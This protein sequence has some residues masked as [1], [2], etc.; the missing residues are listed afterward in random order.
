M[1]INIDEIIAQVLGDTNHNEPSA[2]QLRALLEGDQNG[3][4]HFVNLLAFKDKARYPAEHEMSSKKLSG[5]EAYDKYGAVAFE[6]ITKRGGRMMALANVEKQLVG[7]DK[8]WDRIAT[9][10]YQH[11]DAFIEMIVDPE[12]RAALPHREAGLRAT[13]V[14]VTRPVITS[15]VS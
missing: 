1:S 12:Y 15:P 13:E 8:D 3:P 7:N 2:E 6:Q 5:S 14:I 4:F 9:M 10:E 11:I